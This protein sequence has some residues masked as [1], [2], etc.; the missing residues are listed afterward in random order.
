MTEA[1]SDD[2]L[3]S[4]VCVAIERGDNA[5][6]LSLL[7]MEIVDGRNSSTDRRP[8]ATTHAGYNDNLSCSSKV[9][10]LLHIFYHL[11]GHNDCISENERIVS[12]L[13]VGP[14]LLLKALLRISSFHMCLSSISW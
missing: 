14:H 5:R 3:A 11:I 2:L 12:D 13:C 7:D 1:C 8:V 9:I 10:A 4:D 6:L